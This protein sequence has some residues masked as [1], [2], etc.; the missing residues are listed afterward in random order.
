LEHRIPGTDGF[1]L[2]PF[3]PTYLAPLAHRYSRHK[4]MN[5]I[6]PNV[7]DLH[8]ALDFQ[9]NNAILPFRLGK[10]FP[11]VPADA[12][13]IPASTHIPRLKPD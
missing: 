9:V 5:A 2:T 3:D 10:Q 1:Q 4:M 6:Q 8:G 13:I 12:L 7:G 11:L